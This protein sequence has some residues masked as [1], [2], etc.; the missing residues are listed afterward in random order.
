MPLYDFECKKCGKVFDEI[1]TIE[2]RNKVKCKCGGK[3]K[4]LIREL[5]NSLDPFKPYVLENGVDEPTLITSRQQRN[6]LFR[7]KG[8]D[9]ITFR[10]GRYSQYSRIFPVSGPCSK[11]TGTRWTGAG[12]GY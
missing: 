6:E 7:E 4:I 2:K 3:T 9:Q 8:I 10:Q 1:S 5:R 11:G 12:L